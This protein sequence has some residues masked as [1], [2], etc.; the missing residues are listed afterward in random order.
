MK[1]LIACLFLLLSACASPQLQPY[2][3]IRHAAELVD[4]ELIASDGAHLPF[5]AWLPRGETRAVIVALHG[6]NDYSHGF[7]IPAEYMRL[8]G[9]AVY[10]YDQR[11]FGSA[12]SRG[13]WAGQDNLARDVADMVTAVRARY[14]QTPLYLMGESMGGALAIVA[15]T[16]PG[17]PVIDGMILSA[18]AIWGGETMNPLFR[19]AL[20]MG[21]HTVPAKKVTGEDLHILA[22]DNIDMLR[23]FGGDP[24]VI[25]ATRVDAIYGLVQLM[26]AGYNNV[27]KIRLPTLLLYGAHDMVIPP[28]PIRKAMRQGK[29]TIKAAYYPLGYHMLLRDLHGDVPV[30]DI[31]SWIASPEAPLPSATI[32]RPRSF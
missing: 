26:D 7:E 10:A 16:R 13:I 4:H 1:R 31:L 2:T 25:K 11:G 22:S 21:V 14:P 8:H 27:G 28:E 20:W 15:V 17:F 12:P 24:Q 5:R 18:P 23:A 6:F 29:G 19:M 30:R 32:A 9:V 3:P